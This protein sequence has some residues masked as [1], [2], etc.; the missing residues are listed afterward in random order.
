LAAIKFSA[1]ENETCGQFSSA[2][3]EPAEDLDSP[4]SEIQDVFRRK[5]AGVRLLP[6]HERAQAVRAALEWL[7]FA[8][9]ALREKRAY[10]NHTR[11]LLW[12]MQMPRPRPS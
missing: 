10:E 9:N 5:I 12:R 3:F 6:R 7:W 4:E 2:S 8:M 11:H 1:V